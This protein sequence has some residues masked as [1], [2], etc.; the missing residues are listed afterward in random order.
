MTKVLVTDDLPTAR[1]DRT[2]VDRYTMSRPTGLAPLLFGVGLATAL[3]P[4]AILPPPDVVQPAIRADT[5]IALD[6]ADLALILDRSV[7]DLG[8]GRVALS[9][10][11][12]RLAGLAASVRL[13]RVID[14]G[15]AGALVSIGLVS[16]DRAADSH[17]ST[18]VAKLWKLACLALTQHAIPGGYLDGLGDEAFLA[19]YLGTTA[20]IAWLV[21]DRLATASVTCLTGDEHWAIA[22]AHTIAAFLYRSPGR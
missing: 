22:T 4:A 3:P 1:L 11:D 2:D 14:G 12:T 21:G 6:A 20:Q 16:P 15:G 8:S 18:T 10:V 19:M 17:T 7:A 13:Y 5:H 9:Q